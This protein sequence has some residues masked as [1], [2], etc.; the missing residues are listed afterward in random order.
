MQKPK[1]ASRSRHMSWCVA[2]AEFRGAEG[3]RMK[4]VFTGGWGGGGVRNEGWVC[5]SRSNYCSCVRL[6]EP[7]PRHRQQWAM[8]G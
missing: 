7:P 2:H 1:E 5:G 8:I 6:T 3:S 4:L